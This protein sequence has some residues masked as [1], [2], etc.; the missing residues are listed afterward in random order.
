M[1]KP[2]WLKMVT[3]NDAVIKDGNV[4]DLAIYGLTKSLKT[5]SER[6]ACSIRKKL[7]LCPQLNKV[8]KDYV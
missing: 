2:D 1:D 4:Y 6:K 5:F 8:T 3:D 7:Y